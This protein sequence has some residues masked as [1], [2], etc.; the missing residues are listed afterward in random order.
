MIQEEPIWGN[1]ELH[2]VWSDLLSI[3]RGGLEYD[4]DTYE[5]NVLIITIN[6]CRKLSGVSSFHFTLQLM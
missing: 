3:S 2:I 6:Y 1:L 5:E 4:E